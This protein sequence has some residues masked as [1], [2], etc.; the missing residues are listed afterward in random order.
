MTDPYTVERKI[1]IDAPASAVYERI[2]PTAAP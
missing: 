1:R 2:G